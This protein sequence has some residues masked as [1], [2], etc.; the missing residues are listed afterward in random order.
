M[1]VA[2]V[3]YRPHLHTASF[4]ASHSVPQITFAHQTFWLLS[5][6][7]QAMQL[8]H[9]IAEGFP[10]VCDSCEQPI[11]GPLL[12]CIHCPSYNVCYTCHSSVNDQMQMQHADVHSNDHVFRVVLDASQS[13][14]VPGLEGIAYCLLRTVKS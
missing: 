3:L 1:S 10:L 9:I 2:T 14:A 7:M 4:R 13:Y 6:C 5:L 8:H 11:T 12:Q